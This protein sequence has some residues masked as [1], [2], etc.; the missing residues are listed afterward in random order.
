MEEVAILAAAVALDVLVGEYPSRLHP[1]IWMG[2]LTDWLIEGAPPSGPQLQFGYGVLVVIIVTL[3]T[4]LPAWLALNFAQS[5]HPVAYIVI[6]ALVLKPSFSLRELWGS[7]EAVRQALEASD[8]QEARR[9]VGRIVSRDTAALTPAQ[10]TAAAIESAAENFT[11]SF[12]APIFYFALFGPVG[13]IAYRAVNT[14]DAMIGYHGRYEY[15]GKPAARL[16]DV[17]NFIP[18]RLAG[19]VVTVSA[20]LGGGS[21]RRAWHTMRADHSRPES[22]N[23]GWTMSAAAGALGVRLEKVG[24]YTLGSDYQEPVPAHIHQV[25]TILAGAAFITLAAFV[26]LNGPV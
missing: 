3:A 18:A 6:G 19:V 8:L 5:I 16:D 15:L 21:V 13:A 2:R 24:S 23:A 10:V 26:L 1:V 12:M 9:L 7:V 22:P 4:A 25:L 20:S 17:L 14:L 11:D